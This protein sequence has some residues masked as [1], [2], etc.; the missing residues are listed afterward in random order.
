MIFDKKRYDGIAYMFFIYIWFI[1]TNIEIDI[2][3]TEIYIHKSTGPASSIFDFSEVYQI[4]ILSCFAF[5][6]ISLEF[7]KIHA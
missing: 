3:I 5:Q 6:N 4:L 1:D 7:F 2:Y